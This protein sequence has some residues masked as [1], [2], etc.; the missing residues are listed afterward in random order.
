MTRKRFIK[1]LMAKGYSR[2]EANQIARTGKKGQPYAERYILICC[3]SNIPD[4]FEYL[5]QRLA[6]ACLQIGEAAKMAA[7]SLVKA[8]YAINKAQPAI[9]EEMHR[10]QE[11]AEGNPLN[12]ER[13][14]R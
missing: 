8:V 5:A 10:L 14:T 9:I 4:S 2:N 7:E 1:L 13:A 6:L 11:A 12:D 3:V